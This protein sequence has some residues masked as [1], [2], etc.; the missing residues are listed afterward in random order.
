METQKPVAR[1][2]A[3]PIACAIW[4]NEIVVSG[5]PQ[6]VLKASVSRRYKDRYG[7]WKTSQSFSRNEIP[8]AI[9]A[10]FQA[11]E[12]MLERKEEDNGGG[13]EAPEEERVL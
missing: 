3:G 7:N 8:V 12:A 10:L 5:K 6:T 4:E 13:E 9:F 1:F 11:F 2:K